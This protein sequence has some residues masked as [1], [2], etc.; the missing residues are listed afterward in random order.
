VITE[1][2]VREIFGVESRV[3]PHPVTGQPLCLPVRLAS[4]G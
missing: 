3:L 2:V 1:E 4:A